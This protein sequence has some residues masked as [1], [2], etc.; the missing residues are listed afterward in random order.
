MRLDSANIVSYLRSLKRLQFLETPVDVERVEWHD[1]TWEGNSRIQVS[2]VTTND[3]E[4]TIIRTFCYRPEYE[5]NRCFETEAARDIARHL[6]RIGFHYQ[7]SRL[8]D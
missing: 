2:F 1:Y 3:P 7:G 4:L 6:K 5:M 8:T